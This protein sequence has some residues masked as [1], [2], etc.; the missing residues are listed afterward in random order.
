[1]PGGCKICT[2][3]PTNGAATGTMHGYRAAPIRTF[4]RPR[5][6]QQRVSMEI[7]RVSAA[8]AAGRTMDGRA[9]VLFG[10][11]SSPIAGGITLDFVWWRC[12]ANSTFATVGKCPS[13]D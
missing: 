3:T 10:C 5:I 2:A 6:Q 8:E 1:M 13:A 12:G 7:S 9:E 11:D 4:T